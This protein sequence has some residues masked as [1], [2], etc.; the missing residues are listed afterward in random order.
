MA[1]VAT[2]PSMAAS[3][4]ERQG[5]TLS[6]E[7]MAEVEAYTRGEFVT[8]LMKGRRDPAALARVGRQGDGLHWPQP[9]FVKESG[10]ADRQPRLPARALSRHRQ[11]R[12]LVRLQRHP[13]RSLPWSP[14]GRRGDP[15]LDAI[16]AP[17]TSAM[18]DFDTRVVGWKVEGRYNAL[19]NAVNEAWENGIELTDATSDLR[20]AVAAD[21]KMKVRSS[22][23]T[24]TSRAPISSPGW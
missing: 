17:T 16:I 23:A 6:P 2:L 13:G 5:K 10:G 9:T 22:T 18:V 4:Y 20:Q 19:S 24:T 11:D 21:P 15:I 12:Q 7:L 8:D 1:W 3:N 14:Q